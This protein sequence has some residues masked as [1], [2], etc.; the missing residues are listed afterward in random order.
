MTRIRSITLMAAIG[1]LVLACWTATA[2]ARPVDD[3][4]LMD[5]RNVP[6]GFEPRATS[7]GRD[8]DGIVPIALGAVV[9]L[10]IVTAGGSTYRSRID[11]RAA[12]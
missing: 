12:V 6:S 4:E 2:A 9:V 5:A 11:R 1:C 3:P 8:G 10:L 7:S